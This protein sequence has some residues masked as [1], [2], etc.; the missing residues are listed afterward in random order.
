VRAAIGLVAVGLALALAPVAVVA[1]DLLY[2]SEEELS[3]EI[4]ARTGDIDRTAD[5]LAALELEEMELALALDDARTRMRE[6]EQRLNRRVGVLY[7]LSRRGAALK[8]L[9]SAGSATELLKRLRTLKHLVYDGLDDRRRAGLRVAETEERLRS[10]SDDRRRALEML[11]QLETAR[12]ELL[13]EQVR[14]RGSG[15][16]EPPR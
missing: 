16:V 15:R 5:R 6:I 14:R 9:L 12:A 4:E 1:D 2:V 7:R 3:A 11:E 10:V 13:A 8:Y